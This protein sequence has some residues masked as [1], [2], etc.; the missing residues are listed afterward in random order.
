[1]YYAG[2]SWL[3]ER[4]GIKREGGSSLV[5][6]LVI[7]MILSE[8]IKDNSSQLVLNAPCVPGT[9]KNS[10]KWEKLTMLQRVV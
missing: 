4:N 1:M 6:F 3:V 8:T 9:H 2:D 7:V 10:Q 5:W